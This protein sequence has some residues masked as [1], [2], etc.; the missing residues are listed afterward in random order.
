MTR[1]IQAVVPASMGSRWEELLAR[2]AFAF[3]GVGAVI[4]AVVFGYLFFPHNGRAWTEVWV[5][6]GGAW[7]LGAWAVAIIF[8]SCGVRGMSLRVYRWRKAKALELEEDLDELPDRQVER[9]TG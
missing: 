6:R 9:G 3:F 7:A 8:L 2:R 5:S 4:G 1:A